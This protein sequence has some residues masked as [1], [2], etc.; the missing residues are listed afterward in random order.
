MVATCVPQTE[1]TPGKANVQ[2]YNCNEKG[3]NARNFQKPRVHAA[4][5]E[6]M[7]ELTTAVMLMARI[8]PA[9]RNAETVPSYDAKAVSEVN[10]SSKVHEQ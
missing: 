5:E 3:H 4:K 6:T 2:C 1:S 7:E 8:R 9:N 10:A